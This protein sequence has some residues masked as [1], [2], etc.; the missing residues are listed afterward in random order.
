MRI[1]PAS[2]LLS[3]W[4]RGMGQ[5]LVRKGL[6]LL[7]AA[8]PESSS[9]DL[10]RL[11]IGQRNGILLSLREQMFGS[12]FISAAV[13]SG[14]N[15]QLQVTFSAADI[16]TQADEAATEIPVAA[17]VFPRP[18]VVPP[19]LALDGYEVRFRLPDSGDLLAIAGGKD[20]SASR[21]QLLTRCLLEAHH[22]GVAEQVEQLPQRVIEAV[23]ERMVQADPQA[24]VQL[25]L[26]CPE[27]GHNW[28]MAFDIVSYLWG[29]I[30]SW[31]QRILR[32]VHLLASAYGWRESD[33]LAMSP[34]R[35]QYYLDMT[36]V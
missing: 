7:G 31:A 9:E 30:H 24:D 19:P 23:M 4:E 15:N 2:D 1:L 20:I 12:Q 11:S 21:T 27:C 14:C 26:D 32:D 33:I 13:C 17:V 34:L 28:S 6:L 36:T 25:S 5:P 10:I 35:R 3:V 22:D 29:E 18:E 8:L 16:R